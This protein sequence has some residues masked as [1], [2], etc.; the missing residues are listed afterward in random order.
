MKIVKVPCISWG[1]GTLGML[2]VHPTLI[3][4]SQS[5]CY[6]AALASTALATDVV[7]VVVAVDVF[8]VI[9]V[10]CVWY[11]L[12]KVVK[13]NVLSTVYLSGICCLYACISYR[14]TDSLKL[15]GGGS[16][17][18]KLHKSMTQPIPRVSRTRSTHWFQ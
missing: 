11:A 1:P 10:C 15:N 16:Q 13:F 5:S 4:E 14:L 3:S 9:A 12:R 18:W 2:V 17:L 8:V 6:F 7:V